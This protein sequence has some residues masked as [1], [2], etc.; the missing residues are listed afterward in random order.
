MKR[1]AAAMDLIELL[2]DI[3][4]A[5]PSWKLQ[6]TQQEL[7]CAFLTSRCPQHSRVV[8]LQLCIAI[9]RCSLAELRTLVRIIK[10]ASLPVLRAVR[11][12]KL[13]EPPSGMCGALPHWG[14]T[15]AAIPLQHLSILYCHH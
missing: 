2:N 12:C 6:G 15:G 1:N 4:E 11:Y 7:L 5:N 13:A 8:L 10:I 14:I 9:K 3:I